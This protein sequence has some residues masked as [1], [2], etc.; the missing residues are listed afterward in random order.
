MLSWVLRPL[1]FLLRTLAAEHAPRQLALGLAL[2]MVVG[3]VPKG[4][5]TA[6]VLV[7][8]MMSLRVNL[9]TGLA[10]AAAFSWVGMLVDPLSHRVGLWLLSADLLRPLWTAWFALPLAAWSGLDN[11]VVLGSLVLGVSLFY[12][13][14]RLSLGVFQRYGPG[15][16]GRLQQ[17]R[18]AKIMLRTLVAVGGNHS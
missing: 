12:W 4:N 17:Y 15:L 11:S 8:L 16:I 18:L 13:V 10:A 3:L 7:A 2:G 14:Y 1:T 9:G 5:L 6:V